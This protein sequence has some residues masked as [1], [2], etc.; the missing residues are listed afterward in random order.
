MMDR[1]IYKWKVERE[2]HNLNRSNNMCFDCAD[3]FVVCS[4]SL[5]IALIPASTSL[6]QSVVLFALLLSYPPPPFFTLQ[7]LTFMFSF[8]VVVLYQARRKVFAIGAAN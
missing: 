6:D 5:S 1:K 3:D 7:V 8:I 2:G 4:F